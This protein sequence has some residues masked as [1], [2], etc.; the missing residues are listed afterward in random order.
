MFSQ[1]NDKNQLVTTDEAFG[2]AIKLYNR[3]VT[4]NQDKDYAGALVKLR[5]AMVLFKKEIKTN[6]NAF[7]YS[8]FCAYQ[9]GLNLKALKR[10]NEAIPHFEEGVCH[11]SSS[12]PEKYLGVATHA[13]LYLGICYEACKQYDKA[14][15]YLRETFAEMKKQAVSPLPKDVIRVQTHLGRCLLLQGHTAEA[16]TH[17][18]TAAGLLKVTPDDEMAIMVNQELGIASCKAGEYVSAQKY[19]ETAVALEKKYIDKT[20]KQEQLVLAEYWPLVR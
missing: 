11:L 14:S 9:M 15:L 4:S 16:T 12:L 18:D 8:V 7:S 19:L 10:Y 1:K 5:A 17:L 6:Q 20:G 3:A 13:K 2:R